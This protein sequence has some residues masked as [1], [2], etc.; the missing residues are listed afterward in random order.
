MFRT[1]A[2]MRHPTL[3]PSW[4]RPTLPDWLLDSRIAVDLDDLPEC[5]SVE[6][7]GDG[8][9]MVAPRLK[10]VNSPGL[11]IGAVEIAT[12]GDIPDVN[13]HGVKIG[14][15]RADKAK[16]CSRVTRAPLPN[17]S[18]PVRVFSAEERAAWATEHLIAA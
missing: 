12:E 14:L 10:H 3:A 15:R 9:F 5:V 16:A 4:P 7:P 8:R 13:I 11:A 6:A 17:P 1:V 2:P 18:W